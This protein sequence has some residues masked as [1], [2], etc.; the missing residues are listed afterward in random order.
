MR[1][2]LLVADDETLLRH[3]L[4]QLQDGGIAGFT[5]H[6]LGDLTHR[7]WSARPEHPQNAKLGVGRFSARLLHRRIIYDTLRSVNT[8]VFV[9]VASRMAASRSAGLQA[10]QRPG[11]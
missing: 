2:R 1:S 7:A 6:R 11:S 10:C 5:V 9:G 8:K 4:E 3:D